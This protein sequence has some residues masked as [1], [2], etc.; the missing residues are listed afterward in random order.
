MI[1]FT[2]GQLEMVLHHARMIHDDAQRD[3]YFA[4]V[5]DM[6]RDVPIDDQAVRRAAV[7][8]FAPFKLRYAS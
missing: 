5:A 2:D 4:Q 3:Q 6:L 8:A 7:E 1:S